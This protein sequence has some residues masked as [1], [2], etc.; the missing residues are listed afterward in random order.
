MAAIVIPVGS[1]TSEKA[2]Q[3]KL[4]ELKNT[5]LLRKICEDCGIETMNNYRMYFLYT[6]QIKCYIKNNFNCDDS[7]D[8]E[9]IEIHYNR[10][11]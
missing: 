11:N 3:F 4:G 9:N 1:S 8:I 7:I 10:K 6:L 5:K 2:Y